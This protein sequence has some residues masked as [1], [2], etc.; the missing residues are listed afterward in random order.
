M[1]EYQDTTI[2]LTSDEILVDEASW[3][4]KSIDIIFSGLAIM[5]M[6]VNLPKRQRLIIEVIPGVK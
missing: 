5:A 2:E 4:Q 6:N 3:P 1:T